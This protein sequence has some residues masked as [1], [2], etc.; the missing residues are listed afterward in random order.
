[1]NTTASFKLALDIAR[2]ANFGSNARGCNLRSI[3]DG[4]NH[5]AVGLADYPEVDAP[6]VSSSHQ[7]P[8]VG[9]AQRQAVHIRRVRRKL[10]CSGAGKF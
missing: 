9:R 5:E 3:C 7:R 4:A 6:V 10:A 1:M 2:F 8:P